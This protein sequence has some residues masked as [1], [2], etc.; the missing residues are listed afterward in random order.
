MRRLRAWLITDPLIVL[1]TIV[2]GSLSLFASLWDRTGRAPHRVAQIWSRM[3][4]AISG[5]RVK[6]EGVEKLVPGRS[7]VFVSNHLSLMDT[8]LVI[9]NVPV[10]FRFL[11]KKGLFR[12]PFIGG[13][14]KRAGHVQVLRWAALAGERHLGRKNTPTLG[15]YPT[16]DNPL[17]KL[18]FWLR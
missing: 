8:P 5:I 2:M 16:S 18:F 7:Y 13:H 1:A 10:Q 11:A 17:C 6:V 3:L 4:L 9:G 12:I 14:L 15:W